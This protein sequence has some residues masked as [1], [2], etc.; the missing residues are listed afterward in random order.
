MTLDEIIERC[1]SVLNAKASEYSTPRNRW[2]NFFMASESTCATTIP[3]LTPEEWCM[4]FAMKHFVSCLDIR[5]GKKLDVLEKAGDL[6]NYYLIWRAIRQG[7]SEVNA[8]LWL[9]DLIEA[10]HPFWSIGLELLME[11]ENA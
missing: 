4:A 9:T 3:G 8:R 6:V 10:P 11:V 1:E 2:H 5:A 7:V